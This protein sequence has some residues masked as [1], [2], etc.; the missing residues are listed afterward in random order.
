[1][2]IIANHKYR[3]L[4]PGIGIE[5]SIYGGME[6]LAEPAEKGGANSDK[7]SSETDFPNSG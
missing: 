6:R 1:M 4:A 5:N 2:G 7:V 3:P